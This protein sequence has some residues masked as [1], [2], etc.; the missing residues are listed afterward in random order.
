MF[1]AVVVGLLMVGAASLG[2]Y[3]AL[4]WPEEQDRSGWVYFLGPPA[5][6]E[7]PI[8]IGCTSRDPT[9]DRLPEIRTMS[10]YP[11]RIVWK[12]WTPD[13][14]K[15]ERLCHE[16][17]AAYRLHGEWFDRDVA[18]ALIEHLKEGYVQPQADRVSGTEA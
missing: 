5:A 14:F 16:E 2:T 15:S 17:L 8:K 11:L 3:H 10:P 18:L 7:G 6:T 9:A 12:F 13:R 1:W 4:R